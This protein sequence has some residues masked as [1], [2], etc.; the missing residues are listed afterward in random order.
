MPERLLRRPTGIGYP[1][2]LGG[3][4]QDGWVL[5]SPMPVSAVLWPAQGRRVLYNPSNIFRVRLLVAETSR[6]VNAR[7]ARLSS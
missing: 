5:Y 1:L 6:D 4:V 7:G 2:G 3:L